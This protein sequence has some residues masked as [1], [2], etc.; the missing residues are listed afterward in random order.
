MKALQLFTKTIR[1]FTLCIQHLKIHK[2]K[3]HEACTDDLYAT[4]KVLKLVQKGVPFRQ[5]Y[6]NVKQNL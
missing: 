4:E 2:N 5:A 1:V 3:L 6:Q